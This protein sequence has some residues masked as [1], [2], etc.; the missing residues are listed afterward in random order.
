MN[1]FNMKGN[2][3]VFKL[4]EKT[5]HLLTEIGLALI[6][7]PTCILPY[8]RPICYFMMISLKIYLSP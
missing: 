7:V 5:E 8:I 3:C 6:T 1:R 2:Y 4:L